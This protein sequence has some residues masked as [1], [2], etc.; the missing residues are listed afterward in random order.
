MRLRLTA[1]AVLMTAT[2]GAALL[3][4][5]PS[6]PPR[7]AAALAA[8]AASGSGVPDPTTSTLRQLAAHTGLRVGTAVDTTALAADPTYRAAVAAQFDTV[9]PENVMKW[10]VVEPQRGQ[11]DFTQADQL[12]AFAKANRQ[13]VRGHT[14]VWHN[15][16]PSWLTSG[17]WT[18]AQLRDI[19]R[20]HIR[21]EAGHFRGKLWA[22]DVVNEAFND[23][24][25]LRDTLWLRVIGPDYIADAF[26]WAHQADPGAILFYNDFNIE[27]VNPKSD[28]VHALL[29]RLR[30]EGVPVQ[31]VGLQGHLGT[32]FGFPGDVLQNLRRFAAIG[33]DTAIT[34]AD[35]RSI[36]P[37]DSAKTQAQAAGYSLLLQSCL[38]QPRCISFTVWGFS[39]KYQW[40]PGTFPGQGSAALF[41]ADFQPKPAY[42]AVRRDLALAP[43]RPARAPAAGLV[44]GVVGGPAE[45]RSSGLTGAGPCR[46]GYVGLTYDDGPSATTTVLLAALRRARLR[47]TMFDQGNNSIAQPELVRAELRAGMWVG[48]HSY[49]HP[50]LTQIGEPA[51]FQEIASTQWVLR[52]VTGR[53]PTLFRPPFGETGDQV[54]AD[55]SRIGVLEV[56]WTVDSRDW[57]GATVEEIVAAA[58]TL[59]PGGIILMHDWPPAT[60]DAV[61]LIARDLAQRG[62]CAGR[63]V[64]TAQDVPFGGQ[65]FHAVAVRP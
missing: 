21:T 51:A 42:D 7:A 62:L 40:V 63:I 23:D 36:L 24:G 13:R 46:N 19:L 54:R 55:E 50:H 41:D 33:L 1:S 61:P 60:I 32:Q 15:Q 29:S 6:A 5:P 65:V 30:R 9:T 48:N 17:T 4:H 20:Q 11:F 31:G 26:R 52:D 27:G 44:A 10:E 22:W 8:P 3:A 45:V 58:H 38:L 18:R 43:S 64:R 2:V 34:E 25:T 16:L 12:V 35:V 53:E 39:D 59:Q 57:A 56:L 47:A 49:S 14:L 37:M 28:A